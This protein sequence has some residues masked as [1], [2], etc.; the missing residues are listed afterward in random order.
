MTG[1]LL[2]VVPVDDD[3]ADTTAAQTA[4]AVGPGGRNADAEPH[5]ADA[6]DSTVQKLPDAVQDELSRETSPTAKPALS[7][8]RMPTA[9]RPMMTLLGTGP[10]RGED[11]DEFDTERAKL[12]VRLPLRPP[13]DVA[14]VRVPP[15]T[16]PP[17]PRAKA[18]SAPE[19]KPGDVLAETADGEDDDN[20]DET[21]VR[22]VVSSVELPAAAQVALPTRASGPDGETDSVTTR[23]PAIRLPTLDSIPVV[24]E[25]KSDAPRSPSPSV[26]DPP[27]SPRLDPPT[28]PVPKPN[29]PPTPAAEDDPYDHDESVTTRG[30]AVLD[31]VLDGTEGTTKKIKGA[32]TLPAEDE[33]ESVTTQA[34]GHLTNMLRVIAAEVPSPIGDDEDEDARPENKTAVM[35]NRPYSAQVAAASPVQRPSGPSPIAPNIALGRDHGSESALRVGDPIPPRP[36]DHASLGV[37]AVPGPRPHEAAPPPFP[38]APPSVAQPPQKPPR[39]GTLVAFMALVSIAL[40]VSVFYIL[41]GRVEEP[42][43]PREV[44]TPSSEVVRLGDPPRTKASAKPTAPKRR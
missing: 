20:L 39:Y 2:A 18:P 8:G 41:R 13:S 43:G 42:P 25:K 30:P 14:I 37:L 7:V 16:P 36:M 33:P 17:P 11:D 32:P 3:D 12:G 22:T 34:P 27:T 31:E 21:E 6:D 38:M 26:L 19:T 35:P 4:P 5:G 9:R 23:A 1:T 44:R 28:A 29:L 10:A 40:P 24:T 15:P